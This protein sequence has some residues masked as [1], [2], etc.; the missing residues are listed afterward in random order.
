MG[1]NATDVILRIYTTIDSDDIKKANIKV[2]N[3][4][5]QCR[6]SLQKVTE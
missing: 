2:Q 6:N 4:L 1:D 3:I 5:G